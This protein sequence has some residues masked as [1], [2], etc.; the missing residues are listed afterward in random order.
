MRIDA[1]RVATLR[2]A[3]DGSQRNT[4]HAWD[5]KH[6][7]LVEIVAGGSSGL[8]EMYCDGGGTPQ[9]AEAILRHEIGPHV[10]GQDARQRGAIVASLR[11]RT[12]LSARGT[13]ITAAISAIDIA[14]WDLCGK[15][16]GEPVHR[17]LG[18]CSDGIAVYAS[19]GMYGPG[20]T[21]QSLAEQF[22]EAQ[23]RGLRGAKIKVGGGS[24]D[25]DVERIARVREAIGRDA[26]LMADA[27]FLPDVPG[28]IA[29]G[30]RLAPHDLHFLEA[31]TT[32]EDVDGWCDVAQATGLSLAGPELSDDAS[33]MRRLVER[34]A[35]RYL[36]FDLVI[37]GG[38]TRARAL[39]AFAAMHRRAVTLHCAASAVAM[40]AAAH[41]GASLEHCDG[42]EFH[43]MH[44]GLREQL[45][46]CGWRLQSGRLVI[47]E[48]PGLGVE[49]DRETA[50]QLQAG[51]CCAA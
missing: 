44:D 13:A 1:I 6:Y 41:V 35:V 51:V 9:V 49:L 2:R 18:A 32:M 43:L 27:M 3:Y 47:P 39:A 7:V 38:I 19:G 4:R 37:A 24:L 16:C 48:R 12:A 11:D 5:A 21:P 31:P 30:R 22:G 40:A 42:M 26:P 28:A 8:G 15:A 29:L 10:V 45:W 36:Q 14:L 33:L 46:H 50:A 20:V 23:R 17:L 34:N 25:E